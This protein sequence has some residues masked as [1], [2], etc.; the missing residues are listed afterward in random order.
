MGDAVDKDCGCGVLLTKLLFLSV[1][2]DLCN[3]LAMVLVDQNAT[4]DLRKGER[5][6]GKCR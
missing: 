4:V 3:V 2:F 6:Q 1:A 5:K